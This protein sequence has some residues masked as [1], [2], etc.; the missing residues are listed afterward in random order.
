[1]TARDEREQ[2][3]M[4]KGYEYITDLTWSYR[5]ARVLQTANRLELFTHL[6]GKTLGASELA[7]ACA[8]EEPMLGK[9]LIACT[10]MGL[11]EKEGPKYRNSEMAEKYLVR[12]AKLYQG[13]IIAHS[14]AKWEFWDA[15]PNRLE[16]EPRERDEAASHRNFI[17][18][19]H[20]ITSGIRGRIF[21]DHIDL[22]GRQRLL[23][24]G[25]GPGTYSLLACRANPDLKATVFDLPE[26]VAI[27]QQ[28]IEKEGMSERILVQQGDW[29]TDAFGTGYDA[30]LMSNVL[31]GPESRTEMKLRKAHD[32]LT[33]GGL[34]AIQEFLL[35]DEK[36]GP[37]V[38]SL[39]N[40]MVGAYS[41][42]ELLTVV[43]EQG[44][45]DSRMVY[46]NEEIG[47]GWITAVKP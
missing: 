33:A 28:V 41:R 17:L 8:A 23:D 2:M 7:E 46:M 20:N 14:E 45:I 6:A 39:F 1:M 22:S 27:A 34:L 9:L 37:L 35:N 13:E 21:L 5:A 36:T 4:D 10:A 44:F 38:A 43:E 3:I 26:T 11:L 47:S 16:R 12:G 30:A 40:I 25:G 42:A 15:L 32:S 24:I 19:M 18:G 29:N 31:H